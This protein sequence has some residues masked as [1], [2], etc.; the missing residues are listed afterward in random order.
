MNPGLET[1]L[2]RLRIPGSDAYLCIPMDHGIS[3]GPLPGIV[4]LPA[5][6]DAIARG[7]ASCV[8]FHKGNARFIPPYADKLGF[9]LHLSASTSTNPDPNDKVLVTTVEEAIAHGADA[10]STHTNFGSATESRQLVDLGHTITDAHRY[11]I[12]VLAMAYPRGKDIKDPYRADLLALAARAAGE[13][14]A[15]LVKV[16]YSG[17]VDSFRDVVKG[18]PVPILIAGGPHMDDDKRLLEIVAGATEAGAKGV[19]I[20]RNVFQ[21]RHPDRIVAALRAIL[22]DGEDAREAGRHLTQPLPA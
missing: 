11:G 22:V 20:G 15:D 16:P 6:L 5:T 19:S 14:G 4:D 2:A 10:V 21:H 1:R 13:C 8:V 9:I 7:G 12:P 18:C 3:V 17:N